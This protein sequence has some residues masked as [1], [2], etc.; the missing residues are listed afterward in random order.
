MARQII[1]ALWNRKNLNDINDNFEEL[2]K[3]IVDPIEKIALRL[4]EEMKEN[5][6]IS[7]KDSVENVS[8]LPTTDDRHT[9]RVVL[10]EQK[11]Y[12]YNG[13]EWK[14]FSEVELDP[15][16][17]IKKEL[18][19]L[20][21]EVQNVARANF[22]LDSNSSI[23]PKITPSG[24]NFKLVDKVSTD[25]M[26]VYQVAG[27]NYLRYFF[28]KN[29]GGSGYG[30]NYELLRVQKVEAISNIVVYKEVANPTTGTVTNLWNYTGTNSAEKRFMPYK[31]YDQDKR[32]YNEG[33]KPL[34]AYQIDG[35]TSVSYQ[36]Q[37]SSTNKM[38]IVMYARGGATIN[39][40]FNIKING[41][42]LKELNIKNS[43]SQAGIIYEFFIPPIDNEFTLTIENTSVNGI[44]ISGINLYALDEYKGQEVDS[45][46]AYGQINKTPFID[47]QGSSDYALKNIEDGKQFGSYHGGETVQSCKLE[48]LDMTNFYNGTTLQ[49][50]DNIP[51]NSFYTIK[52]LS[53]R[54]ETT[55]IE[56]AKTFSISD[57]NSNGSL[58]FNFSY[59]IIDG[60]TP[61]PLRD[62]WVGLT[63]TH[64][65]F[66]KVKL[67]KIIDFGDTFSGN[68][69]F[70]PSSIGMIIQTTK[71]ETQELHIR[72]S[73][74]KNSFVATEHPQ[75][76]NDSEVYRK[77]YYAPI[78]SNNNVSVA[79][80]T[81]QFSKALDFYTI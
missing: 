77:Y 25:E 11:V 73:R 81:F 74:F 7:I 67:P 65:S 30:V 48:Y 20:I 21:I 3:E 31:N 66:S 55:L 80:I 72:H 70:F 22:T 43:P 78:R 34:Q 47:S 44:Y 14:V 62:L 32:Y 19:D 28:K 53:I 64:P 23:P 71:D 12:Q 1:N 26:Y 10:S 52:N 41:E 69:V 46:V 39:E 8:D 18:E 9:L 35:N 76:I 79:P 49:S 75:S 40:N 24:N 5:N 42:I 60:Q 59:N 68:T 51:V 45:Y 50:F 4:W 15:Y 13:K 33:G 27:N 36:M 29:N 61:I 16:K 54:Q 57:F 38:N 56:R 2:Y 58:L 37:P 6:Q 17:S 63:C